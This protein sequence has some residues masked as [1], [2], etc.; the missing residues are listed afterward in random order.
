M[1]IKLS[2]I[3]ERDAIGNNRNSSSTDHTQAYTADGGCWEIIGLLYIAMEF[4][5][6][7]PNY[8]AVS[9]KRKKF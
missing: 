6:L 8:F 2:L 9:I 7:S 5:L 1:K 4:K 3:K